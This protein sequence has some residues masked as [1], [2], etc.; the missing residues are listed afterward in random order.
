VCLSSVTQVDVKTQETTKLQ[1]LEISMQ[2]WNKMLS[3]CKSGNGKN[4]IMSDISQN[5]NQFIEYCV[6][7]IT[8]EL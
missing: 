3:Q 6:D 8:G 2:S 1:E 7:F 5:L 4:I